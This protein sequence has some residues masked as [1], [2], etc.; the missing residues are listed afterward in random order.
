[1]KKIE[2][3]FFFCLISCVNDPNAIEIVFQN[4]T[5]GA[6]LRTKA[7]NNLTYDLLSTNRPIEIQLEY[8][9][10]EGGSLLESIDLIVSFV[11]STPENGINT[12]EGRL[13]RTLMPSDFAIGE[14]DFP[15]IDILIET[16]DFRLLHELNDSQ[17]NCTDRFVLDLNLNLSDG[18]T[19]NNLNST[20]ATRSFGGFLNSPFS[21]DIH[22][23]EGV[24]DNLF[25]GQY[26]H[27]SIKDGFN[28]PTFLLPTVVHMNAARPN[29]RSFEMIRIRS[30][31]SIINEMEYTIACDQAILTRYLRTRYKCSAL[32]EDE[33]VVLLGPDANLSESIDLMD[34]T[35]F[36]LR[37]LEAFEGNDG[38]CDW[39]LTKSEVR[40][41]KQ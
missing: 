34:D 7:I 28:G 38:F 24:D 20:S 23:V 33:H 26:S 41:S 14:N 11:D 3:L 40:F 16:E 6:I 2:M 18:R 1:M 19:F 39:P 37:F 5:R 31:D 25:I 13:L 9:D 27:S 12:Q 30:T 36:D 21:Y 17:L 35:V 10:N 4:E 22:I 15:V 29:V 8:Q 32:V